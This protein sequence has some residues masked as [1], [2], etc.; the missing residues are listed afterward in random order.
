MQHT[1]G[2]VPPARASAWPAMAAADHCGGWWCAWGGGE[3]LAVVGGGGWMQLE[4]E[5]VTE[6]RWHGGWEVR[7]HGGMAGAAGAAG[8]SGSRGVVVRGGGGHRG[9]MAR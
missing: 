6:A 2:G 1:N 7:W 4:A 9:T 8:E 5:E 3:L